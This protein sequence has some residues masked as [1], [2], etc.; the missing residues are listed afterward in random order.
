METKFVADTHALLWYLTADTRLGA[1]AKI[2]M[3]DPK[4]QIIIPAIV[5]AEALYIIEHGKSPASG[6]SHKF[7][8]KL[9]HPSSP[10]KHRG[11]DA[12]TTT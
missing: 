10:P 6:L 7:W 1:N 5:V 11:G 8:Y 3:Q 4:N 12:S 2:A 9:T